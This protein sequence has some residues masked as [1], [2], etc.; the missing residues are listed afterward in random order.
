MTPTTLS[1]QIDRLVAENRR[2]R[3]KSE[4]DDKTIHLIKG[5][6]E[7]LSSQVRSLR[8]S[9]AS[10]VEKARSTALADVQDMEI[11]LD[12]AK[13]AYRE[14]ESILMQI[15]DSITQALRARIGNATPEKVPPTVVAKVDDDRLPRIGISGR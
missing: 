5:Q 1:E 15:T 4:N 8:E 13:Q 14:I 9:A 10:E 11:E 2:L 6:Y 12:Q 7:S 3:V